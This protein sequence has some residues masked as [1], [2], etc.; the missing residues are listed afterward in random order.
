MLEFE[1]KLVTQE[2]NL[3]KEYGATREAFFRFTSCPNL[4]AIFD[5]MVSILRKVILISLRTAL[6]FSNQS[7]CSHFG[8][9]CCFLIPCNI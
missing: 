2:E 1:K 9:R 8:P 5:L 6:P 4:P 3:E 7:Y